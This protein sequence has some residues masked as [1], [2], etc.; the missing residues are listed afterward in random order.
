M[1]RKQNNL[2][3]RGSQLSLCFLIT[4]YC[5]MFHKQT[6]AFSVE[7]IPESKINIIYWKYEVE[8]KKVNK[9]SIG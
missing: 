6:F 5:K 7:F 3:S 9:F 4:N 1:D 8:K 2:N